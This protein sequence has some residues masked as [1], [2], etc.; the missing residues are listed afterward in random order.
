[1]R[2]DEKL[3][4]YALGQAHEQYILSCL[5]TL[6]KVL[7]R[8]CWKEIRIDLETRKDQ[9]HIDFYADRLKQMGYTANGILGFNHRR[10]G[11]RAHHKRK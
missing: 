5:F 1:V 11:D 2:K 4:S 7:L 8:K 3:L 10:Q 6:W 9:E